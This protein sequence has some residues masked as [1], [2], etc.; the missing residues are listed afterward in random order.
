MAKAKEIAGLDCSADAFDGAAQV[1][2]VRFA[3]IAEL[4]ESSGD[5]SDV[6]MIHDLRVGVR[7]LRSALR[8]FKPLLDKESFKPLKKDLKKIADA[9]GQVR[10]EDVA[11][12]ALEKLRDKAATE[13]LK[14]QIG[15]YMQQRKVYRQKACSELVEILTVEKLDEL[16]NTLSEKLEE[17]RNSKER[18]ETSFKSFGK[19]V[20]SKNLCEFEELSA[21]LYDPFDVNRLHRLRIAAKRLRYAMNIFVVC[22]GEELDYFVKPIAKMQS[23]L[24]DT[25]DCDEWIGKLLALL[26]DE[27]EGSDKFKREALFWLL[28]SFFERRN[29]E[30]SSALELWTNWQAEF[31][32]PRLKALTL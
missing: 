17:A 31:F 27:S 29:T 7:R 30:Y 32:L 10:D 8:D 25:H 5:F 12:E 28:S 23:F 4:H 24:G 6:E 15:I 11:I 9:L 20:I 14:E 19:K 16:Q 22:W 3:E 26:R 2:L 13:T 18:A 21:V 1:L